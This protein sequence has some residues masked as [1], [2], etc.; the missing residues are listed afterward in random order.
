MKHIN[1]YNIKNQKITTFNKA[2]C[3]NQKAFTLA[4]VLITIGIIGVVAALTIPVL[5]ANHRKKVVETRLAKFYSTMN[6]ALELSESENGPKE[7]WDE[8]GKTGFEEDEN[9]QSDTSKP[10]ALPWFNKYLKPYLNYTKIQTDSAG[11][12][13]IYFSDGSLCL[14]S[15]TA[16]KVY[17]NAK[18]YR[19]YESSESGSLQNPWEIS[20]IKYFTFFYYPDKGIEPYLLSSWDGTEDELYNNASIGCRKEVTNERAYCTKIIQ[21]NGWKIPKDYP[22]RF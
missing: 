4:E 8:M 19:D 5:I 15:A 10:L 7:H 18:D 21:M 1:F 6:Q 22:L 9:G 16:I 11:K 2:I 12:I 17:P 20:G 14:L 3:I 13:M